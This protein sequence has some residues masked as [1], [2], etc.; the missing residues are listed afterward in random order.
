M[1]EIKEKLVEYISKS[2]ARGKV[3]CDDDLFEMGLVHSLFAMQLILFI[4]KEFDIEL[5]DEELD[6]EKIKTIN[7][8]CKIIAD[9][10][11]K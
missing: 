2:V 4:E 1:E 3:G 7:D 5:D 6:F 9:K 10:Q 8:I 11:Y